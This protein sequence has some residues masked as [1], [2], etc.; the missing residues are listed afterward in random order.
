MDQKQY[1]EGKLEGCFGH[2]CAIS[3]CDRKGKEAEEWVDEFFLYHERLKDYLIAQGIKIEF[4][5]DRV[6]F[7]NCTDGKNCKFLKFSLNKDIDPRPNDCKIY[8]F[9]VDWESIDFD[10]KIVRLYYMDDLCPLVKNNS[11]PDSFRKEVEEITK[12]SFSTL[13]NGSECSVE[14]INEVYKS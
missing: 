13:F 6:K 4:I 1:I 8:P 2:K 7:S 10:K 9:N 12:K 14:F 11:I 3:C 5:D